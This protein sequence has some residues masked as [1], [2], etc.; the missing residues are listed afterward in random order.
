MSSVCS[1]AKSK[2]LNL[3]IGESESKPHTTNP[4][5]Q[6]LVTSG[7]GW[8]D[9]GQT[10]KAGETAKTHTHAQKMDHTHFKGS[11][12]MWRLPTIM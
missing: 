8:Q 5:D 6:T 10:Q 4:T 11:F 1:Q 9:S 7:G 3:L 2:Q 12:R